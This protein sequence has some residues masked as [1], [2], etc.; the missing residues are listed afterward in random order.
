ML[1]MFV[2]TLDAVIVNV[3]L[4]S[5][6][7]DLGG[8]VAG[9]QWV[10]DAYTLMFAASLLAAGA[11]SDRYGAKRAFAAGFVVFV[12]ASGACGAAPGLATLILA[13]LVQGVAAAVVVP[14]SIALIGHSY[15]DARARGRAIGLWAVGGALASSC[16]PVLGGVLTTTSWRLIFLVNLP[17]GALGLLLLARVAPSPKRDTPVQW[18]GFV[19]G[20]LA[21]GSA[22][23]AV[24]EAGPNGITSTRVLAALLVTAC[25]GY[26]FV[27]LQR[28]SEHPLVP[29]S[30]LRLSVVRNSSGVGAAFVIGYYGLPFVVSI[31]FQQHRG[32]SALA[33][34]MTFLPMMV[35]GGI[36]SPFS[37][38]MVERVGTHRLVRA[39]LVLMAVGLASVAFAVVSAP[40]WAVALLMMVVGVAGPAIMPPTT[41]LLLNSVPNHL[42]GTAS[43]VFNTARQIGGAM[44]VAVFGTLLSSGAGLVRGA[45]ISLVIAALFALT[46]A[47]FT[48]DSEV[49]P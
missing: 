49:A 1:G 12:L 9:M 5:I 47:V 35:V 40:R 27:H 42:A 23:F 46:T 22:T 17:V 31:V 28:T 29:P 8:G 18:S 13:R 15:P 16:G 14:S 34:G 2:V 32:M 24:I 21:I 3:A 11:A 44:A 20:T 45:R 43:G 6:Q 25:A 4:P 33:T 48:R 41:A 10:A 38:S 19:L 7:R 37:A 39:G 26:S 30:L 36:L